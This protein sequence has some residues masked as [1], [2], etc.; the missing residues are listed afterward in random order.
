MKEGLGACKDPVRIIF[1]LIVAQVA[2]FGNFAEGVVTGVMKG[3][4]QRG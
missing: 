2:R 3:L 1:P 4:C